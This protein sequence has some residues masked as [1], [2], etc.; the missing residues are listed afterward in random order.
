MNMICF[1]HSEYNGSENPI[2]SCKA[3]CQIFLAAVKVRQAT[4]QQSD[5]DQRQW[6]AEKVHQ[7]RTATAKVASRALSQPK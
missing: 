7:A 2:L 6:M 4:K 3:C 1:T 5:L